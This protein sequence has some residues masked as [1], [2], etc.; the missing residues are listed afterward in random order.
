MIYDGTYTQKKVVKLAPDSII[1]INNSPH[2]PVCPVCNRTI[3]ISNYINSISTNL[4][5]NGTVGTA[6]FTISIPRHGHKGS[7]INRGGKIYGLRLMDE[8]DIYMKGL[9]KINGEYPYYKVFWGII[10]GISE[11]Y[12]DGVQTLTISCQSMLRWLQLMVTNEHPSLYA[13][14]YL[15]GGESISA[16]SYAGRIFANLNVY[17]IIYLMVNMTYL[18]IV[19]PAVF[20][21]EGARDPSRV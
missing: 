9:F 8:V 20:G 21:T 3:E 16:S 6:S 1:H 15:G 14:Q 13:L 19:H 4:S 10:S 11:A 5:T 12:N 18:N 2:I 17:E 7:Y